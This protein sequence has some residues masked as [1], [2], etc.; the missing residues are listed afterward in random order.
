MTCGPLAVVMVDFVASS[1]PRAFTTIGTLPDDI[2]PAVFP[3]SE[4]EVCAAL[5]FRGSGN[6]GGIIKVTAK[7]NVQVYTPSTDK[8]YAGQ[9]VFPLA[10]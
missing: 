3:A 2:R 6:Y 5:V 4:D 9:V 1:S 10:R 7:G 8:Y